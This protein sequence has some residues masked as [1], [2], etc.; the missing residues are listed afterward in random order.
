[1]G[2]SMGESFRICYR[3]SDQWWVDQVAGVVSEMADTLLETLTREELQFPVEQRQDENLLRERVAAYI[4]EGL[5]EAL[6][7][8]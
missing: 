2:L 4:S 1:M 6:N 7:N 3:S 5:K 8:Q